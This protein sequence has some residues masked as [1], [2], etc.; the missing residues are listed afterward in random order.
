MA[1]QMLTSLEQTGCACIYVL[2]NGETLLSFPGTE[3]RRL[4]QTTVASRTAC[5][6]T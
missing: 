4:P 6:P 1:L 2:P 3:W 5:S